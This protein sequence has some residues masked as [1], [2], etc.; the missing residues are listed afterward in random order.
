MGAFY[1]FGML[2]LSQFILH[3]FH[4]KKGIKLDDHDLEGDDGDEKDATKRRVIP[5]SE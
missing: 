1:A 5:Y 3:F 2:S 4:R